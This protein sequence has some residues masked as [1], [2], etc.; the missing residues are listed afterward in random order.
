[1][2]SS[3]LPLID[4]VQTHSLSGGDLPSF[5]VTGDELQRFFDLENIPAITMVRVFAR[6]K[7]TLFETSRNA[8]SAPDPTP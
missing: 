3:I 4:D 6:W 5:T 2:G 1:M 8:F 7:P